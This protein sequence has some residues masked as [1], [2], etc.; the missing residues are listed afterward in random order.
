MKTALYARVSTSDQQTL[1]MQMEAMREYTDKRGW[2]IT[3]EVK[4]IASGAGKTRPEREKLL[5]LAKQRKI[6]AIIVMRLD[7]WGRSMR[8]VV[9]TLDD[10]N[11]LGVIFVSIN[12]AIDLSTPSGEAMAGMLAVLSQYERS[13]LSQRVKEGMN[14]AKA[15]GIKIGRPAT[16][17]NQSKEIERLFFKEEMNKN[18]IAKKLNL[19]W[20]SV[21]NILKK[22]Q[23]KGRG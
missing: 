20:G 5:K 6:D 22:E 13:L 17:Q 14:N 19:D 7:R 23:K 16:A 2:T 9:T 12:E 4:E 10:L 1:P 11:R 3:K 18:Q 8:D 21:N 15:K